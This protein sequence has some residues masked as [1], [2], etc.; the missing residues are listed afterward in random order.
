MKNLLI[1]T[2]L[3]FLFVSCATKKEVQ[4]VDREIVK[5]QHDTLV[6]GVHDSVF[7][8]IYQKGDTIYNTKYVEKIKY[9]DRIVVKTDTCYLDKVQI[10]TIEKKIIPKWCY[11]SLLITIVLLIFASI[12][13]YKW[14]RR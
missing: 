8:T 6:V 4:Y 5:M 11:Y 7:H 1:I 9:K 14:I 12:K 13:L 3:A 10:R 2:L